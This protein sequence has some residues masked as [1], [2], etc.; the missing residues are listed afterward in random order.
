MIS[1]PVSRRY[2]AEIT[3]GLVPALHDEDLS[4]HGLAS[5]RI[6]SASC[7]QQSRSSRA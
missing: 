4:T 6:D 1:A 5:S 7:R 2:V 3:D